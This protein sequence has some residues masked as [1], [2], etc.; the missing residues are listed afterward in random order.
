MAIWSPVV[1]TIESGN[2]AVTNFPATQAVS[3]TNLDIRDLSSATDSVAVT[4]SVSV[5]NFP[6]A[7][8]STATVTNTSVGS[9]AAVTLAAS[10]AARVKLIVVN[11]AGT[12]F[13]KLGTVA[14]ST[15]YSYRLVAGTNLEITSYTGTVT[16]IKASGTSAVLVTE[17]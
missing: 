9:G 8:V 11:E 7:A 12:L 5:S 2:I 10:N 17:L 15:S 13:V 4:G 16:A 1:E 3:A 6:G 14:S